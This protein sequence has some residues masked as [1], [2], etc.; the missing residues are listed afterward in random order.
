MWCGWRSNGD[1]YQDNGSY[2]R[3][4]ALGYVKSNLSGWEI[5]AVRMTSCKNPSEKFNIVE[6]A[7]FAIQN[8]RYWGKD[9]LY[10]GLTWGLHGVDGIN[11]S[12]LDGHASL[13][14]FI[15]RNA[16]MNG[17]LAAI[18]YYTEPLQ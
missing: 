9:T 13:F 14:H 7:Y 8:Y 2:G 15:H 10:N 1:I 5:P 4:F 12:F 3:W 18:N 17:G 6:S 11:A 16:P